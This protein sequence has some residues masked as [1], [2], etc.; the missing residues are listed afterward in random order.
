LV[1]A[2]ESE[3]IDLVIGQYFQSG[4]DAK[5]VLQLASTKAYVIAL[6]DVD[7]LAC[8]ATLLDLGADAVMSTS[9]SRLEFRARVRA[10]LRRAI[11]DGRN[12]T[13]QV[14]PRTSS[15]LPSLKRAE[16]NLLRYLLAQGGRVVSQAE[17]ID[18]VFGGTHSPDTA[19]VRVHV[20]HLRQKLGTR[21]AGLQTLRGV[22]Y[23][24]DPKPFEG[25][26]I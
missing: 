10:I 22:G 7:T 6:T 16:R 25:W 3:S 14:T 13:I 15:T 19:L 21:A 24:L 8:I 1:T 20:S 4:S 12:A 26:V 9:A 11:N 17:L 2:L 18:R 23:S 5:K